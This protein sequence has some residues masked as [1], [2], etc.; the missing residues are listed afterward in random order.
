[1]KPNN[2]NKHPSFFNVDSQW[3]L[4]M[5]KISFVIT[6]LIVGLMLSLSCKAATPTQNISINVKYDLRGIPPE[7]WIWQGVRG[8]DGSQAQDVNTLVCLSNTD[9]TYGACPITPSP[10]NNDPWVSIIPL[11]FCRDGT[12]TCQDLKLSV[13]RYSKEGQIS[14]WHTGH[15]EIGYPRFF[16]EILQSQLRGLSVGTWSADLKLNLMQWN[17]GSPSTLNQ[18][19]ARITL[20]VTDTG[21]QTIFFPAFP[22][23]NAAVNLNLNNRPGTDNNTTASGKSGLDMCLYDGGLSSN[24]ISLIFTDEGKTAPGRV[25]GQFSV[26]R[27]SG[28][29]SNAADR[30]DYMVQVLNPTTGNIDNV[31]N[32]NEIRW[33]NTN[34]RNIQRQVVLP[35]IPGGSLCVPAPITLITPSFSLAGKTAGHYAGKLHV[36]Y[37]PTTSTP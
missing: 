34:A 15:T 24:H 6:L 21:T 26:Y 35:G 31:T 10:N 37:S 16:Y 1:M 36:I 11:K 28:D 2:S 33:S 25:S 7:I 19:E 8:G 5:Q 32:G 23:G 14:P 12:P 30:L 17:D 22:S 3:T 29:T 13:W 27:D 4:I 18:W 20:T 9:S